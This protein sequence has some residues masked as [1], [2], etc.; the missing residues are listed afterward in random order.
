VVWR[1][2]AGEASKVA[3]RDPVGLA[4]HRLWQRPNFRRTRAGWS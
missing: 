2:P 4:D 1:H 3:G